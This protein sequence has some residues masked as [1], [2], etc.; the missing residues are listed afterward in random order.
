VACQGEPAVGHRRIQGEPARLG[1]RIA[2][3]TVR[4]TP[5]AAGVDSAPRRCGPPRR[6]FLTAQAQGIIA[7]DFLHFDI[8]PC[9]RL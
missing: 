8:V 7:A 6:E 5:H 9:K 1:H 3:S 2:A 4:Q